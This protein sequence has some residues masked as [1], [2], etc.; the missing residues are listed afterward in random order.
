MDTNSDDRMTRGRTD[1]VLADLNRRM[2][3][4]EAYIFGNAAQP[5]LEARVSR[6]VA[7]AIGEILRRVE[8]S[9]KLLATL[10][11]LIAGIIALG[12]VWLRFGH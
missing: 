11:A 9:W 3:R 4:I 7:E 6:Q 8:W 10:Q 1:W 12:I 2:Q 5:S